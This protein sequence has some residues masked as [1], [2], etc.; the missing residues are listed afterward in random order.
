MVIFHIRFHSYDGIVGK[1]PV[2]VCRESIGLG[3][4]QQKHGTAQYENG[5]RQSAV[6]SADAVF[7][8]PEAISRLNDGLRQHYIGSANN[9]EI[10]SLGNGLK[11]QPINLSKIDAEW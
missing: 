11:W 9:G 10:M 6:L 3:L 1:S 8:N 2:Q 5:V 7:N 4:A